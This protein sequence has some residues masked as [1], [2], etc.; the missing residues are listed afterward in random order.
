MYLYKIGQL[1][2]V[3]VSS[4]V[5]LFVLDG[6]LRDCVFSVFFV[7]NLVSLLFLNLDALILQKKKNLN[8]CSSW[9]IGFGSGYILVRIWIFFQIKI[10][11]FPDLF[12]NQDRLDLSNKWPDPVS[13]RLLVLSF[14][15]SIWLFD[16]FYLLIKLKV[17]QLLDSEE[18]ILVKL[19]M[20]C[21]FI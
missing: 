5:D 1:L 11:L 18:S 15:L 13:S 9:L 4:T 8:Q 6:L 14:Y 17:L 3:E 21:I 20:V 19:K 2:F 12:S 7:I 10:W 16:L